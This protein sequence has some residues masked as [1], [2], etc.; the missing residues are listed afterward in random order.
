M[1]KLHFEQ[2]KQLLS[3]FTVILTF[4]FTLGYLMKSTE[5]IFYELK[6]NNHFLCHKDIKVKFNTP[7][8]IPDDYKIAFKKLP[9]LTSS[10]GY[11]RV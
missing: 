3:N 5:K 10:L 1:T 2:G 9:S 8:I 7:L 11:H 6:I 4:L